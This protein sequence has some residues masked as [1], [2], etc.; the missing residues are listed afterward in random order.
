MFLSFEGGGWGG[1][2][3]MQIATMQVA[4]GAEVQ[5]CQMQNVRKREFEFQDPEGSFRCFPLKSNEDL[6]GRVLLYQTNKMS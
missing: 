1:G 2:H 6:D 3:R 4:G 5:E